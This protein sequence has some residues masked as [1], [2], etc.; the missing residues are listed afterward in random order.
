MSYKLKK[1]GLEMPKILP[2][3]ATT[4]P[5]FFRTVVTETIE[6]KRFREERA[7]LGLAHDVDYV[8]GLLFRS[9]LFVAENQRAVAGEIWSGWSH[10][11]SELNPVARQVATG[12]VE[13]ENAQDIADWLLLRLGLFE[14]EIWQPVILQLEKRGSALYSQA[15][16][17]NEP[18]LREQLRSMAKNFLPWTE[19]LGATK[20]HETIFGQNQWII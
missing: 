6:Q 14:R 19:V 16:R 17:V 10:K 5:T 8:S 12:K 20:L 1:G 15:A 7:L 3:T 18:P 9:T 11:I 2:V 4:G 13:D